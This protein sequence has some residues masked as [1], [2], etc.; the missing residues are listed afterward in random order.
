M[1]PHRSRRYEDR[2][3]AWPA[4]DGLRLALESALAGTRPTHTENAARTGSNRTGGMLKLSTTEKCASTLTSD[5]SA[6]CVSSTVP[7][8]RISYARF[9]PSRETREDASTCQWKFL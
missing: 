1:I 6:S 8:C 3:A 2:L 4:I 9:R 7:S 5:G